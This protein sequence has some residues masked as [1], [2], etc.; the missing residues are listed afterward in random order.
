MPRHQSHS[1]RWHR[2]RTKVKH[3]RFQKEYSLNAM[4]PLR[5]REVRCCSETASPRLSNLQERC[6]SATTNQPLTTIQKAPNMALPRLA[7]LAP[8]GTKSIL[9]SKHDTNGIPPATHRIAPARPTC[10]AGRLGTEANPSLHGVP[11]GYIWGRMPCGCKCQGGRHGV[12]DDI[13]ADGKDGMRALLTKEWEVKEGP[14]YLRNGAWYNVE[15][16]EQGSA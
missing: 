15:M 6:S 10:G 8:P 9:V 2:Q 13:L 4:V 12:T 7:T 14:Y 5:S 11:G 16:G 3:P 1:R